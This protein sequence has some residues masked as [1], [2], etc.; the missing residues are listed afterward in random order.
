MFTSIHNH[1][2]CSNLRFADSTIKVESLIDQAIELGYD[3]VCITD[4]EAISGHVRFLKH[5]KEL[6]EN[7]KLPDGFKIGLGNEIY[8]VDEKDVHVADGL[9][10]KCKYYHMV[11]IA[12][13]EIGHR[14]LRELSSSAW[15]GYFK[16]GPAE[17][18]P[19]YKHKL[20]EI[21]GKNKGHLIASTACLGGELASKILELKETNDPNIRD[22]IT[23]FLTF[24][25]D[26]FGPGNVFLEMQPRM[27]NEGLDPHDQVIVNRFIVRLAEIFQMR[28]IVSTDSHYLRKEDRYVHEA[29]LNS[30]AT[31]KGDRELSDF[32]ETAYMMSEKEVLRHLESHL[33]S[34]QAK[35]AVDNTR[36]IWNM[37]TEYDLA[38][39]VIVPT[40]KHIPSE[41]TLRGIFDSYPQY[42]YIQKF[43]NSKDTQERYLLHLIE[44]GFIEK[45]QE[46]NET[47][48]ARI[49]KELGTMWEVSEKIHQRIAHY[50]VL[51][52][53][54]IWKVMWPVSYVGVA[55][56]SVTGFYTCYLSGI[57]Q[58]NPIEY[59]LP[60]WRHLSTSRVEL[61]DIDID[62]ASSKRP[63]IFERMR[64]YYGK[65]NSLNTLA[66]KTLTAKAA[67]NTACRGLGINDDIARML[68]TYVPVERGMSWT[69]TECFE[70]NEEKGRAPV[71][72]FINEVNGY[73][74]LHLKDT[75]LQLE[76]LVNGRSL[77]ASAAYVFSNGYVAQNSLLRAPNG[78]ECTAFNMHDSDYMGGLKLDGLTIKGLDKLQTAMNLL[79][80][81][82]VIE[83]QG[84]LKATYDKYIHPDV[85]DYDN[86]EAWEK[87]A[88]NKVN[89]IFQFDTQVGRI[90][91]QKI[92]PE[93]IVEMAA[94]NSLMRL[95]ASDGEDSPIDIYARHK[96]N[97]NLWYDEMREHGLSEAD[98]E[99][100]KDHLGVSYGV[101]ATQEEMMILVMDE[102][103]SGFTETEANKL[104][105]GV[106]K[107]VRTIIDD[108]KEMFFEKGKALG[109][110]DA[111]LHYVWDVQIHRQLGYSFSANHTTPYSVI[112]FQELH[113]AEKYGALYWNTACLTVNA[114]ADTDN[115]SND[116]TNY[117]KIAKAIGNL[118]SAGQKIMPPDI[119]K[120][121]FDFWPDKAT[122]SIIYSLKAL[123]GVGDDQANCI[124]E[125]RP[126]RSFKEFL[127]K[128]GEVVKPASV[129]ALIKAGAFDEFEPDRR[130]LM[131]E[132]LTPL[133]NTVSKLTM[134]HVPELRALGVIVVDNYRLPLT[135]DAYLRYV[136]SQPPAIYDEKAN[137]RWRYVAGPKGD[138]DFF[139]NNVAREIK[140]KDAVTTYEDG[141]TIV[142][143]SILESA[144]KRITKPFRERVLKDPLILETLN[145][146]RIHAF[147]QEKAPGSISAWEMDSMCFYFGD[148]ELQK[149]NT[150]LYNISDFNDLP[151]HPI[152]HTMTRG[153]RTY[154]VK[155]MST[156]AGTVI[157]RNK[158]KHMVTI[159]TT[160][161]VVTLKFYKDSF[162][163]FDQQLSEIVNGE[164][165]VL[166]K[167]WFS[168]GN[169]LIVHGFRSEDMF[170]VRQEKTQSG[171]T[172]PAVK[173][174][175]SI[176]PKTGA[177]Q[178]KNYRDDPTEV[179]NC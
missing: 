70:G 103:I 151:E 111:L 178:T 67:I 144:I 1:T 41:V 75:M 27:H 179:V 106:A 171:T 3:G 98:M 25:R 57:T 18:A 56:G 177:I 48:L 156:I 165:K 83:D 24:L 82:G 76:G 33:E 109:T 28:Y 44:E 35:I 149:L 157:D 94:A 17:R 50:Y 108:C 38:H 162:I 143:E 91:A 118:T 152:E 86:K 174:I 22:E 175:T 104:R 136:K 173:L 5:Y 26:T 129:I 121:R 77:H 78:T 130:R 112:G 42:K 68:T 159:L 46:F 148:H 65:E 43:R 20:K 84:S 90:A 161:G 135:A 81:A 131:K 10:T 32:Y 31:K 53:E 141:Y 87:L 158:N 55:R 40:D 134:A 123:R 96:Q 30:D 80:K 29:F 167:S 137:K 140:A 139:M 13:D 97:I 163:H 71:T 58:I 126:Y 16:Q 147:L 168:H 114:G 59:N 176:N 119:N 88:R 102:R 19:T 93:N 64:S 73:E 113:L 34:R 122:N 100:M 172:I 170:I 169:K 45:K 120:A 69:L 79:V 47:N 54:L 132:F 85:L 62:T 124:I 133:A 110:S 138:E 49:D 39:D 116:V 155:E 74:H 6:K 8:L 60:D 160:T 146:A 15:E 101:A 125:N 61:P 95:M 63:L 166:E 7:G 128:T 164:K 117:G 23:D 153:K 52:R 36:Y 92:K 66:F 51:V 37:L 12:K 14:Q 127:E 105:K 4:H 107:K 145:N 11:L 115:D 72:A 9:A 99:V 154:K 150:D 142:R 2:E 21:V 89:D